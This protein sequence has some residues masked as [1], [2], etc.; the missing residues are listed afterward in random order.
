M[1]FSA[2]WFYLGKLGIIRINMI[3]V[4]YGLVR[5]YI[6]VRKRI[7]LG[8]FLKYRRFVK[9]NN[10]SVSCL[11][12]FGLSHP[13]FLRRIKSDL[14][15]FRD[16]F[17]KEDYATTI[18]GA[19]RIVDAG[20]NIGAAT[21]IFKKRYPGAEVVA[22]EPDSDNCM[23]FKKNT[24]AYDGVVLYQG[25]IASEHKRFMRI[26]DKSVASYSYEMEY[27]DEGLPSLS[28]DGLMKELGWDELDVVKIDIE[29]GEKE[30][31]SRNTEWLSKTKQIIIELHD[32]KLAGC[33]HALIQAIKDHDFNI[34]FS[35]ENI[36]LTKA[37]L[38]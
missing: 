21:L 23:L 7:S 30:M 25:G 36:V 38:I 9:T 32:Y 35:G 29:G 28:I 10:S 26:K 1:L 14:S 24:A 16:F 15:V 33:S 4:V 27:A 11:N 18:S 5:E 20:A 6:N 22:I 17:L 12:V 34:T 19:K 13:F 31:L 3:K 8:E 2:M 37:G